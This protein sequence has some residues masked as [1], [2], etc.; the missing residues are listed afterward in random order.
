MSKFD[1]ETQAWFDEVIDLMEYI[2]ETT[3]YVVLGAGE[4][5]EGAIVLTMMRRDEFEGET[6]MQRRGE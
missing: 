4:D 6:I 3:D 2:D 1:A 5:D